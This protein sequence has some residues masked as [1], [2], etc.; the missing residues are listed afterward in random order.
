[1]LD[2]D[3]PRR[4][5]PPVL[6]VNRVRG[7]GEAR[8]GRDCAPRALPANSTGSRPLPCAVP[9]RAVSGGVLTV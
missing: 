6:G 9:G 4:I 3:T 5:A 2:T 1:V 8:A 7:K